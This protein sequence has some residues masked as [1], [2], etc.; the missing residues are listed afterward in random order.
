MNKI[1]IAVCGFALSSV[2]LTS[3]G[4]KSKKQSVIA[5]NETGTLTLVGNGEDFVRKGFTSKD[6]W[7]INFDHVYVNVA[8]AIAYSTKSVFEPQKGA[9]TDDIIYRN[10]VNFIDAEKTIDLAAGSENF[11]PIKISEV[12]VPIDFYNALTWKLSTADDNSPASGNTIVLE[13]TANKEDKIINFKIGLNNPSEYICGEYVGE[14]RLGIVEASSS[15]KVEATLHFDHIFGD[16]ETLPKDDLN[17]NA[18]GF[19]PLATL[20]KNGRLELDENALFQQLSP[21]QYQ[22]LTKAVV[23]LG[24]VGEGHCVVNHEKQKSSI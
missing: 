8:E 13:G 19:Q 5:A 2:I 16:F 17:Q 6:G 24:H 10:K 3:F 18:L 9:K 21:Q 11:A 7:Q 12:K 20:A 4:Q 22:K 15:G 23:G 14:E 1:Y